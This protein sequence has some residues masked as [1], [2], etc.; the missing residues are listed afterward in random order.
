M[1][2]T[3]VERAEFERLKLKAPEFDYPGGYWDWRKWVYLVLKDNLMVRR[4][5]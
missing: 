5:D 2:L 3:K 4:G 1:K